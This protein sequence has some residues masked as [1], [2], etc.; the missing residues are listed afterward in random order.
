V[1]VNET[2]IDPP[3]AANTVLRVFQSTYFG[4]D[5]GQVEQAG[6]VS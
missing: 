1:S 2:C 5:A 6:C 4:N 3:I